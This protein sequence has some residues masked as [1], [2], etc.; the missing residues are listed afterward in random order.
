VFSFYATKTLAT[1]EGGMLLTRSPEIA[2][3]CKVMR[4]HGIDRD[5]FNRYTSTMPA[6]FYRVV[7]PGYKYNMTDIA[8]A[9][10]IQQLKKINAFQRKRHEMAMRYSEAFKDLC[11]RRPSHAP[12]GEMHAWH[13]YV[14]RLDEDA[15]VTRDEFIQRMSDAG[16]GTSVHF[17]PL[18][19]QPYWKDTYG[20]CAE[21][22]PRAT[23]AFRAAVSL[24]I[25]TRMTEDDQQRVIEAVRSILAGPSRPT[26]ALAGTGTA[27]VQ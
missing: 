18:H 9:I 6:W 15:P 4:L 5:A 3:R 10:G 12:A 23:R 27:P 11:L 24:P 26:V 2:S 25:Y 19:L 14:V 20:L 21:D 1:G 13:L 8:A 17:I 22:F 7:A 16:I